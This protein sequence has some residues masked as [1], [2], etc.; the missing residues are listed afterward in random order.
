VIRNYSS[1]DSNCF[2]LVVGVLKVYPL[3]SLLH[4]V[5]TGRYF[6][7]YFSSLFFAF[8][9]FRFCIWSY[10]Y[11][12]FILSSFRPMHMIPKLIWFKRSGEIIFVG[13][14]QRFPCVVLT[15]LIFVTTLGSNAILME[16]S[17]QDLWWRCNQFPVFSTNKFSS[18]DLSYH[19]LQGTIPHLGN[20][21]DLKHL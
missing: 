2:L 4:G 7:T 16:Q 8:Q 13:W 20:F 17:S 11:V 3:R 21:T 6:L 1:G 14:T 12:F 10:G 5:Y 19:Y 18:R 9:G 15:N